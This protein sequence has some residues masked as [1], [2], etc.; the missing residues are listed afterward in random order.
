M[1]LLSAILIT[2]CESKKES[3]QV[4]NEKTIEKQITTPTEKLGIWEISHTFEGQLPTCA[5]TLTYK[6]HKTDTQELWSKSDISAVRVIGNIA[7]R[8]GT[9]TFNYPFYL[10]RFPDKAKGESLH[11][12]WITYG[13]PNTLRIDV[14][15]QEPSWEIYL[16][17]NVDRE[18]CYKGLISKHL[19]VDGD[20]SIKYPAKSTSEP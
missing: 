14:W 8:Q 9:D 16:F 2:F 5:F 4:K 11:G 10:T 20:P 1:L 17:Q 3:S 6:Q 12:F 18:S 15:Q 13:T 19:V 7:L